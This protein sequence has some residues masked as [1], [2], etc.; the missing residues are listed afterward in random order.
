MYTHP[1]AVQGL[2]DVLYNE[3][4]DDC[5][6]EGDYPENPDEWIPPEGVTET[7]ERTDGRHRQ[8]KD[9]NGDIFRRWDREGI[10][11]GEIIVLIGMM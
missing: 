2:L 7:R 4:T 9:E 6:S 1:E 10:E 8:W 5:D 3:S 11:G